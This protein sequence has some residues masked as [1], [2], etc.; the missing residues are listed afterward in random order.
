MKKK[1]QPSHLSAQQITEWAESQA[2]DSVVQA[3]RHA[4]GRGSQMTPDEIRDVRMDF[5]CNGL[6][7]VKLAEKYGRTR[8]TISRCLEGEEFEQLRESVLEIAAIDARMLLASKN[9]D[10]AKNWNTASDIAALKGDHRPARDALIATG[11]VQPPADAPG[12]VNVFISMQVNG[13]QM[14]RSQRTGRTYPEDIVRSNRIPTD[15][16]A[17]LIVWQGGPADVKFLDAPQKTENG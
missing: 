11:V 7:R 2:K 6:T 9:I 12:G 13:V 14:M 5:L 10:H 3:D 15:E 16:Q 8:N 4:P 17:D 1:Q